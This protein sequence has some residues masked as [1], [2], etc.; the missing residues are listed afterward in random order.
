MDRSTT[1]LWVTDNPVYQRALF[2]PVEQQ[3]I[4]HLGQFLERW[5]YTGDQTARNI[6]IIKMDGQKRKSLRELALD[7][8]I[9]S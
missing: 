4:G 2:R 5:L 8:V 6:Q 3:P 7:S 9:L 1:G